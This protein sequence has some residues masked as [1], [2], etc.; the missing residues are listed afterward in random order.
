MRNTARLGLQDLDAALLQIPIVGAFY[1]IFLRAET[2]Y[3]E[4]TRLMYVTIV[5]AIVR[6]R[7][8]E[9]AKTKGVEQVEYI[10]ATPPSHPGILRMVADLLRLGWR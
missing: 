7:I 8:E 10:D 3:G 5:D 9:A 2:Y 4:D 6:A 1:E